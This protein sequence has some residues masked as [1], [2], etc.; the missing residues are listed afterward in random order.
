MQTPMRHLTVHHEES[1]VDTQAVFRVGAG[2][3]LVAAAIHLLVFFLFL[4]FSSREAVNVR[5]LY[6]LAIG[7]ELRL[8]PPPR[9]QVAPR[10]DLRDL[11]EREE[12]IL[13]NYDWVDQSG[14]RIRIPIG[15]AMRLAVERGFP[16]RQAPEGGAP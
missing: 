3:A 8:P 6:P 14:G 4:Y 5:P 13:S 7:Q 15:E 12:R 9:L 10:Q 16:V 1:D 11:R 2:L